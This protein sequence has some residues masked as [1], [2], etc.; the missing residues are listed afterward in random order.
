MEIAYMVDPLSALEI[1]L[2][3]AE[4]LSKYQPEVL[5]GQRPL[6]VEKLLDDIFLETESSLQLIEPEDLPFVFLGVSEMDNKIIK[7]RESD[8]LKCETNGFCRMTITHE[9]GHHRLHLPQFEKC[10]MNL[11]R[12]Q[13]NKIPAYVSSEWQARVWASA[14]L[15]PFPAMVKILKTNEEKKANSIIQEV[16]EKFLVSRTAAKVRIKTLQTYMKDG[17]FQDLEKEM[18]KKRYM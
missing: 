14:T 5:N 17:R 3:S 18:I 4:M 16:V 2:N 12:T 8:F 10:K 7:I 6:D 9:V 11:Y 15:M 1:E 13:S